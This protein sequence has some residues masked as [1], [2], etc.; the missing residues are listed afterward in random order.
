M[1]KDEIKSLVA[2]V[3]RGT[4]G[5]VH[6]ATGNVRRPAHDEIAR[7]AFEIYVYN[8]CKQGLS[9]QDWEQAERELAAVGP[10]AELTGQAP[11]D[12]EVR[13]SG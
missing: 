11:G 10:P 1:K 4:R 8:G 5:T 2:L 6:G 3:K 7:R 13:P 9:E 12:G